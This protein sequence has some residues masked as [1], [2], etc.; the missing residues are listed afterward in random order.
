MPRWGQRTNLAG[1]PLPRE[2]HSA[3]WIG[4]VMVVRGV[5]EALYGDGGRDNPETEIRRRVSRA[6]RGAAGV[7]PAAPFTLNRAVRAG[8]ADA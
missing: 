3:V 1:A 7:A 5:G 6:V 8:E 4:K 2:T